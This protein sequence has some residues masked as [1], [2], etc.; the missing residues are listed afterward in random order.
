MVIS[1]GTVDRF[2][3]GGLMKLSDC[4]SGKVISLTFEVTT[5]AFTDFFGKR[6]FHK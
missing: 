4:W 2:V 3:L 6:I 5:E 1:S